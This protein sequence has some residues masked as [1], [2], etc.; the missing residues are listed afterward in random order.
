[1]LLY[2]TGE[3]EQEKY[4]VQ[5]IITCGSVRI[6]NWALV[7]LGM[8]CSNGYCSTSAVRV[9]D[10]SPLYI[11]VIVYCRLKKKKI[12]NTTQSLFGG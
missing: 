6:V 5:D 12:L 7:G 10:E 2:V 11:R 9:L 3:F 4:S 1:M 8:Y